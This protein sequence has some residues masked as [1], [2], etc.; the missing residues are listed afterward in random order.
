MKPI[1]PEVVALQTRIFAERLVLSHVLNRAGLNRS[2]WSRWVK[3]AEPKL[4]HLD[5]VGAVVDGMIAEKTGI[6]A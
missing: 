1:R 4:S 5:R 2:T 3:G 6:A